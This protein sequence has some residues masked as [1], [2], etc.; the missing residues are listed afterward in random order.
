MIAKSG[1]SA[2]RTRS[3]SDNEACFHT[4]GSKGPSYLE[5]RL[6]RLGIQTPHGRPRHP[7]TQGKVERFHETLQKEYSPQL[8]ER[9]PLRMQQALDAYKADYNWVRPHEAIAN[10]IPGAVYTASLKPRPEL[11]PE[12]AHPEGAALRRV[13]QNGRFKKKGIFYQIGVGLAREQVALV[14]SEDGILVVYAGREFA[15][16]EEL[17]V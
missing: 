7:Q 6:W 5:A 2:S 11:L 9:D 14:P 4:T 12:V 13:D 16:L 3:L 15:R 10:K 1:N 17:R 8:K